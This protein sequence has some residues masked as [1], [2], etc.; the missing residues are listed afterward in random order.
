MVKAK[1]HSRTHLS[2]MI[3][4]PWTTIQILITLMVHL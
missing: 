3:Q 4:I 2:I 1:D